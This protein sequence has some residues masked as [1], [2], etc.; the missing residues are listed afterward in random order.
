[1]SCD[2]CNSF[3][4]CQALAQLMNETGVALHSAKFAKQHQ[5]QK[6]FILQVAR[7]CCSVR[8]TQRRHLRRRRRCIRTGGFC[9]WIPNAS[10]LCTYV[11]EG[12]QRVENF[13]Q[14][15]TNIII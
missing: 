5:Q 4:P 12:Q 2:L 3:G 7:T 9:I 11:S 6:I 13:P 1:M 14:N 8:R 10:H 15:K